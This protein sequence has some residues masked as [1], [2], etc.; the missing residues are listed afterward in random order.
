MVLNYYVYIKSD[1]WYSRSAPI[2]NRN[3]G[4]CECCNM[5]YGVSVHH[6]TYIRLGNETQEDLLHVCR[7]CHEMIHQKGKYPIWKSRVEFLHFLRSE[8][9]NELEHYDE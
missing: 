5:R 4:I 9:S 3:A 2:R 6:K 1:E 8:I 7:E